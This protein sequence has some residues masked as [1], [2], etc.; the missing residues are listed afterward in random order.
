MEQD[1]GAWKLG[2]GISGIES[3]NERHRGK[4]HGSSVVTKSSIEQS[5]VGA[6]R[7]GIEKRVRKYEEPGGKRWGV[8]TRENEEPSEK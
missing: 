4:E 5:P 3:E 8:G 6:R 2:D 1:R 7:R